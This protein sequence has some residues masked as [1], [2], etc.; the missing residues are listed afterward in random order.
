MAQR[1]EEGDADGTFPLLHQLARHV[2]DGRNM[3]GI[4]GVAQPERV[5]EQ[6]RRQQQRPA[7]KRE[8]CQPP[9]DDRRRSQ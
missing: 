2:V 5:G 3:I 7:R 9:N 6:R 1:K 4:D 8:K